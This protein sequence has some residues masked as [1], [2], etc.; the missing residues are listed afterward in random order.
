[1]ATLSLVGVLHWFWWVFTATEDLVGFC[2]ARAPLRWLYDAPLSELY[3]LSTSLKKVKYNPFPSSSSSLAWISLGRVYILG[4]PSD[5][6]PL[7]VLYT[8]VAVQSLSP[9]AYWCAAE[10]INLFRQCGG[11]DDGGGGRMQYLSHCCCAM[12]IPTCLSSHAS[13]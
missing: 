10:S 4:K 2:L 13:I 5:A 7:R 1:M 11:A 6:L 8:A 9:V 3:A 12:H